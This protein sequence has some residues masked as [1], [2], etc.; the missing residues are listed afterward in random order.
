MEPIGTGRDRKL[1]CSAFIASNDQQVQ[2]YTD[3]PRL[4]SA[5]LTAYLSTVNEQQPKAN[6]DIYYTKEGDDNVLKRIDL[7][8]LGFPGK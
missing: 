4:E 7:V 5:L 1:I 3:D 2:V 8:D 6:V